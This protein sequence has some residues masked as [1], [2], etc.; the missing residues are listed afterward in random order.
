MCQHQYLRFLDGRV[1]SEHCADGKRAS[2]A[3][4]ILALGNQIDVVAIFISFG[5][6]RNGDAL[7]D[8]RRQ[9]S[10]FLHNALKDVFGDLEVIFVL[11][12]ALSM[13]ERRCLLH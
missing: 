12:S 11:P 1:D 3:G 13:Q 6:V 5:D 7:N 2:F 9:E 8:R 4:P 10:K